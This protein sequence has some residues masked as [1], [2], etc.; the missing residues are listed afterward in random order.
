MTKKSISDEET[1][2]P[3]GIDITVAGEDFNIMPF[4]LK[5][6][7]IVL[8]IIGEV[9]SDY[10]F[11]QKE[12][13]NLTQADMVS[14][15]IKVAGDKLIKIYEVVLEKEKKWLEKKVTIK[16]E[17]K[18]IKAVLEVNDINFLLQQA[19]SLTARVKA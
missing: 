4:V 5:N 1:F 16:D 2:Y 12:V 13:K 18:I 15:L 6:R 11:Q 7:F 14:L 19:K 10:N 8:K 9:I 17:F 3:N